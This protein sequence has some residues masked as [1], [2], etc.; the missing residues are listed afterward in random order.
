MRICSIKDCGGKHR[1][2]G[3]CTMH[4]NAFK[5]NG[6]P[7]LVTKN[8]P[9]PP[10]KCTIEGC[11]KQ[12]H[13]QG[14]CNMHYS[15]LL[16]KG[17][18]NAPCLT[19]SPR[20]AN[21]KICSI[22]DCG[23][24]YKSKGLCNKHYGRL[25]HHG[26]ANLSC[27]P[28]VKICSIKDCGEKHRGLGYC[29]MHY[30]AFKRNGDPLLVTKRCPKSTRD[31]C[32]IDGCEK[33]VHSQNLCSMHYSRLLR[34]G[35]PNVSRDPNAKIATKG[36]GSIH[37]GYREFHISGKTFKEHR[38]V[39]EKHLGRKLLPSENV[40]H[41]NGVRDDNRIENLE[42]W[43]TKQPKGQRPEDLVKYAKEI[44]ARYDSNIS[45]EEEDYLW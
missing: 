10:K 17:D 13:G 12:V 25:L 21:V 34:Y 2:L 23:K 1:G 19:R 42:L 27:K 14:L 4:Y 15:R 29:T 36:S 37:G 30:N 43:V 35:D 31:D 40:H 28:D 33:Q 3:Y 38:L 26:D 5:R 8:P 20:S 32:E 9:Q 7:L 24:K 45:C 18:P 41:I 44:L 16:R 39:M 22:K 11:I 6:D